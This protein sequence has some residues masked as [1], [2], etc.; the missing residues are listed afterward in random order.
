MTDRWRSRKAKGSSARSSR[1][2]MPA[3]GLTTVLPS[4]HDS[5]AESTDAP[6]GRPDYAEGIRDSGPDAQRRAGSARKGCQAAEIEGRAKAR[7]VGGTPDD[8]ACGTC[9]ARIHLRGRVGRRWA[10]RESHLRARG[11]AHRRFLFGSAKSSSDRFQ[12]PPRGRQG[13]QGATVGRQVL[14]AHSPL[15]RIPSGHDRR[16]RNRDNG[17]LAPKGDVHKGRRTPPYLGGNLEVSA[18]P[19]AASSGTAPEA[20]ALVGGDGPCGGPLEDVAGAASEPRGV[21]PREPSSS[22]SLGRDYLRGLS[23]LLSSAGCGHL[24]SDGASARA[25]KGDG[26]RSGYGGSAHGPSGDTGRSLPLDQ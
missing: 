11:D 21:P 26:R 1:R 18:L 25:G 20:F 5:Q 10:E 3:K 13:V 17:Q 6:A 7:V 12:V 2:S 9:R 24:R 4:S 15:A 14:A 16:R 19:T 8:R 23:L 22:T